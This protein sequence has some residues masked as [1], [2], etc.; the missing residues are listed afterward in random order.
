ME[1]QASP[2]IIRSFQNPDYRNIHSRYTPRLNREN[3]GVINTEIR[4]K[5]NPMIPKLS[6]NSIEGETMEVNMEDDKMNYN[7]I[8]FSTWVVLVLSL[9][10]I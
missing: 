1:H 8:L 3:V 6:Y 7:L 2:T 4:K 5:N 9:I 10:H